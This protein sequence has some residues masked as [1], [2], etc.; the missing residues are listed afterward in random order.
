MTCVFQHPVAPSLGARL[1]ALEERTALDM[2]RLDLQGVDV[3]AVV[4]LGIG[5][6]RLEHLADDRR[7]LLRR[8]GEES[9]RLVD[10]LAADHVCDQPALLR[11]DART[12]EN[13]SGF[14]ARHPYFLAGAAGAA[15][16]AGWG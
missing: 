3:G 14:H 10:R 6:R 1:E 2:N 4:V 11:R 15:G 16:G 8:E 5:D 7:A 9:H 12:A 13:R